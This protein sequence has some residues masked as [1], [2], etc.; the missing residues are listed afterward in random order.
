MATRR[1]G[2]TA[3]RRRGD[4]ETQR[5]K[6]GEKQMQTTTLEYQISLCDQQSH[7]HVCTTC[8]VPKCGAVWTAERLGL[9]VRSV[10]EEHHRPTR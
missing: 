7:I 9:W 4:T 10:A 3:T 8:V 5:D 6:A 1:H 2:D